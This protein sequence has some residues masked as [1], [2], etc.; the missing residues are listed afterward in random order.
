MHQN[1]PQFVE[2][3]LHYFYIYNYFFRG[4]NKIDKFMVDFYKIFKSER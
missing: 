2:L 4:K 1:T 3:N